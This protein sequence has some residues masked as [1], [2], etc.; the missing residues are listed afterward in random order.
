MKRLET[1]LCMNVVYEKA[2]CSETDFLK[3][4]LNMFNNVDVMNTLLALNILWK[5]AA[6]ASCIMNMAVRF[7][8]ITYIIIFINLF[9]C[10]FSDW[11]L[12]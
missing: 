10:L 4:V 2:D 7:Y 12:L 3:F 1:M 8:F 6:L 9:V 5:T 11:L